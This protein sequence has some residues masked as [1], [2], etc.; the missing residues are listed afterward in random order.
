M[1]DLDARLDR[2][3]ALLGGPGWQGPQAYHQ[4]VKEMRTVGF[5]RLS[6]LLAAR[7][8]DPDPEVR[9]HAAQA[10]LWVDGVRGLDLVLPLLHD[11]DRIVRWDVCGCLHDLGNERAVGPLIERMKHDPDPQ[12]R[13]TAAY[14]L[15]GIRCPSAI[16]ALIETLDSDH[17]YDHMGHSPSSC[18][19]TAL[20]DIA[21]TNE[22]RIKVSETIRKLPQGEPDLD[23]L[24]RIALEVFQRWRQEGL[25]A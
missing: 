18:A 19:A 2:W 6:P 21:G 12:V 7:L 13:G 8:A 4:A 9:C 11:N 3:L 1:S 14:A 5:D 17:E 22:T 24:K 20:D 15:G 23:H 25:P 16:P 10:V